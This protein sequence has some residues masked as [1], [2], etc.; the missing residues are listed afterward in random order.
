[1]IRNLSQTKINENVKINI[2]NLF[3]LASMV[4]KRLFCFICFWISCYKKIMFLHVSFPI[5]F[6]IS[7]FSCIWIIFKK[8]FCKGYLWTV[9]FMFHTQN[10]NLIKIETFQN[11]LS[12]MCFVYIYNHC[13]TLNIIF[14]WICKKTSLYQ[15]ILMDSKI[16]LL[17]PL[18][19]LYMPNTFL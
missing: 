1:M 6:I 16:L 9:W 3:F 17:T 8:I 7:Y 4:V 15:S 18:F 13:W 14:T 11:D 12:F 10:I 19:L 2:N 5:Q